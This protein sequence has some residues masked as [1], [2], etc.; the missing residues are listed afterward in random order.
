MASFPFGP[1]NLQQLD[2]SNNQ[3]TTIESGD[4][5]VGIQSDLDWLGLYGNHISTIEAGGLDGLTTLTKLDLHGNQLPRIEADDFRALTNLTVLDLRGNQISTIEWGALSGLTNLTH[6]ALGINTSM[7]ELQLAAANFSSLTYFDVGGNTNLTAVSLRNTVVNQ[8]SLAVLL[9]GGGS[10]TGIGALGGIMQLDLSGVDFA[11]ITDLV[12]LYAMDDLS[13]LWLVAPRNL[14][15]SDLDQ[16]LD[17]LAT[18]EGTDIEG[19]VRMTRA[20]FDAFNT[21]GGGLL[22]AWDAEPG[23]HVEYLLPGD[24]NHDT[25]AN[26]LDVDP[27]VDVLL[28]SQFDVAAD[29]N[30]DGVVNGLDVDPFVAAV[31]GDGTGQIPEPPTRLLVFIAMGMF[32]AWLK[33]SSRL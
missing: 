20:D 31:V 3:L 33:G 14:G 15:A 5:G 24:M 16:L 29:I 4:F 1:P 17:N 2:L 25:Q 12:P 21:A 10:G 11:N 18:I 28:A 27:F 13:N 19:V 30:G 9:D 7:K 8:T 22:A 26:G 32:G 23:H 6:L